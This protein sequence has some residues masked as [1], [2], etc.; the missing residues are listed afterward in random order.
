M[1]VNFICIDVEFGDCVS[2]HFFIDFVMFSQFVQC[3]NYDIRSINFEVVMQ[4]FM[5]VGMI[6]VISI[7]YVV[8]VSW[9]VSMDLFS[10]QFY[11]VGRC[12]CWS[13]VY[14][15]SD[16]WNVWS[17][18]W[19]QY[20]LVF[21]ILIIMCQFG[22]GGYVINVRIYVVIFC[23]DFSCFMDV[24]QD[25]IGVEQLN[26]IFVIFNSFEFVDI[27]MDIFFSIF[28]Y[29]WYVV[30]FVQCSDVVVNV[31]L[32]FIV[33]MFQIVMYD[34]SNFVSVSWVVRDIVWD[35]Q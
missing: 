16:I 6:E 25:R 12:Y 1:W 33:Y 15:L 30:V 8:V 24:M 3:C 9:Y 18:Q 19:V 29:C 20:V 10:E 13:V 26:F 14:Y 28:W 4:V 21:I 11:I 34:D 23:Q 7:Q 5:V 32:F 27:F 35:S 31:F 2:N 22:E 17:F